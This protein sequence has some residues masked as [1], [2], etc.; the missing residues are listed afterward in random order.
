VPKFSGSH[1]QVWLSQQELEREIRKIS[2]W[3][4]EQKEESRNKSAEEQKQ[5]KESKNKLI[6][7]HVQN[8]SN[9]ATS[10]THAIVKMESGEASDI[11]S[12]SMDIVSSVV[13]VIG[14]AVGPIGAIVGTI[15][16]TICNIIGA[17]FTANKPKQPSVVEQLAQVV[18]QE[19][20]G[21][22]E[23]L[24][25]QKYHGLVDRVAVQ[26][27]QLR[28]MKRGDHLAD[29]NLW[30]DYVQFL[31]E[32]S[33]RFESPLPFKYENN[34]TKDPDVADFVTAVKTYCQA[35]NCFMAL[36]ISAKGRFSHL[37]EEKSYTENVD[38]L[39][40][41]QIEA[42]KTKLAFLSD[43]KYLTF[44]GRLPY[45]G[46]KLTKIVALSRDSEARSK[47]K[48]VT[49]SLGLPRFPDFETVESRAKH[50]SGL[51]VRVPDVSREDFI[52]RYS[53]KFTNETE[54]PM[55]VVCKSTKNCS[56]N[57]EF[58]ETL[59]PFESIQRKTT[60]YYTITVNGYILLYLDGNLRSDDNPRTPD[61]TRVI[62]FAFSWPYG[63]IR[64]INIQDKTGSEFTKGEDT[65]DKMQDGE[66]KTIYWLTKGTHHM[67]CGD[68][69]FSSL[70][71]SSLAL[72]GDITNQ[73]ERLSRDAL[74]RFIVQR[75]DPFQL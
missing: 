25:D 16:G 10:L 18:H 39:I 58:I 3:V 38:L 4:N 21:F 35:Y 33:S 63:E 15:I 22:N 46:G 50:V 70:K 7:K 40:S 49:R 74:W 19:L 44:L 32:L 71:L 30:H 45:E 48:S 9:F 24:Q 5:K 53:V 66:M 54:F 31:G 37:E 65:F 29:P 47:L 34:L 59:R 28:T 73:S 72:M 42:G 64:K 27:I 67:A 17:I 43:K 60:C 56:N 1:D 62:E 41:S 57:L 14:E 11:V 2:K 20:V 68:I 69:Q 51:S 23:K 55:K 13:T 26:K 52:S 61:K 36:L 8:V 12:G 75:Y 6:E